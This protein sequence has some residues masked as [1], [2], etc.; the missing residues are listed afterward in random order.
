MGLMRVVGLVDGV[1]DVDLVDMVD[2]SR[3]PWTCGTLSDRE[4]ADGLECH[5]QWH[6]Q[7]QGGQVRARRAGNV[8]WLD[9]SPVR[10]LT[11]AVLIGRR[12]IMPGGASNG[13]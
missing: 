9:L 11:V 12:G 8:Q 4:G 7:G 10:S 5:T 13:W 6:P 2:F 3:V 1:D